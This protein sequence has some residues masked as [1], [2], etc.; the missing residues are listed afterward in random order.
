MTTNFE[1]YVPDKQQSERLMASRIWPK[2][3]PMS[4]KQFPVA[5]Q[6][7]VKHWADDVLVRGGWEAEQACIL[8][9][10]ISCLVGDSTVVVTFEEL[11]TWLMDEDRSERVDDWLDSF[12]MVVLG[13]DNG[14]PCPLDARA[15][16]RVEAYLKKRVGSHGHTVI[17][18]G[19]DLP[20]FST[21]TQ[22]FVQANFAEVK[23][24]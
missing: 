5:Y 9:G 17:H 14:R 7:Y 6:W 4:L 13:M 12:V 3:H 16:Y 1:G 21:V 22:Q 24:V 23:L 15:L 8:I 10:R 2:Y 19:G 18:S 11:G 20:W